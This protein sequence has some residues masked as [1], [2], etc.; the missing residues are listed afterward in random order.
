MIRPL[1]AMLA[2]ALLTS[3]AQSADNAAV[4]KVGI[5]GLDTSHVMAFTKLLND[6]QASGPLAGVRVVAAYPGG[7][8]DIP[9][10]KDRLA[11]FT[12]GVQKMGVEIV[13]SIDVLLTKV[14]A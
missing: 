4:I 8:Q 13:D 7:S 5:I 2:L 10:S 6:P 9:S 3:S 12:E 11:G 1:A 14:D